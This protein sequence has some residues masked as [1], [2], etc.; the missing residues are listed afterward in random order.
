V[1]TALTVVFTDLEGF[2]RYTAQAG[3]EAASQ[4]LAEH[5]RRIS[6]VVRGRGGRVVKHIGD[7]LLLTFT[8]AEAAVLACLELV[9]AEP[10]PLRL[11]AGAH[12]GEVVL[13]RDDIVGHV[14]NIAARVAESAKGGQVL[15][16]EAVVDQVRGL[17]GIQVGRRRR[18]SFKGV[19]ESVSVFPLSRPADA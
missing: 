13:T 8:H 12:F 9:D 17:R 16:T 1:P 18:R 19:G 5:H 11:R 14:V 15:V 10:P 2:T 3:D 6:P 4:R 7:G